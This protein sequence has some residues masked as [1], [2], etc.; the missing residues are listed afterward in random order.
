MIDAPWT[1]HGSTVAAI[2]VQSPRTVYT[3][4]LIVGLTVESQCHEIGLPVVDKISA[5]NVERRGVAPSKFRNN[6]SH[7]H[8]LAQL[9]NLHRLL[10]ALRSDKIVQIR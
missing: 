5:D 7:T 2:G 8:I 1:V 9:F 4:P 10:P 3:R 6:S